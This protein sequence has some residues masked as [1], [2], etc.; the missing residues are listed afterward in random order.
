MVYCNG[1]ATAAYWMNWTVDHLRDRGANLD[2]A[3][4]GWGDDA[5]SRDRVAISLVHR[6]QPDGGAEVMVID[7]SRR[8]LTRGDL[9]GQALQRDEVI[10]TPLAEQVFALVDAIYEQ[11]QRF[12]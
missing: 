2:L 12:F 8:P 10:G 3:L 11:D 6:D 5:N 7:A 4:G 9:V 1:A